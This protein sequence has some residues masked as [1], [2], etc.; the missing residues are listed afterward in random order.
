MANKIQV[1]RGPKSQLPTL[2]VGE[3]A[4]TTDTK[5]VFIGHPDGNIGIATS[6]QLMEKA[7]SA[8][9]VSVST[10]GTSKNSTVIQAALDF[11]E[12]RGG[13]IVYVPAGTYDITS[14]VRVPSNTDL[15]GQGNVVF[16]R[17]S[18]S[19]SFVL[20]NKSDGVTGGYSANTNI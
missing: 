11:A 8:D 10:F 13:G 18:N 12:A 19:V 15:I 17:M 5:E 9:F 1:K 4:L 20:S 7:S 2:S 6:T 16:K 3:P 14:T